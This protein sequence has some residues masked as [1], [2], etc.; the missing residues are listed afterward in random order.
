MKTELCDKI[1]GPGLPPIT[2]LHHCNFIFFSRTNP[3]MMMREENSDSQEQSNSHDSYSLGDLIQYP[4]NSLGQV[5]KT[6]L[7]RSHTICILEV[8]LSL[9]VR[10]GHQKLY[11]RLFLW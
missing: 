3:D 6:Q 10:T 7:T 2:V 11:G 8:H 5:P 9:Q 1:S 4:L